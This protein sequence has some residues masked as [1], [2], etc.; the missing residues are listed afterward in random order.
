MD[1][2][3]DMPH[4]TFSNH[5]EKADVLGY[6]ATDK[7]KYLQMM[8]VEN[9]RLS[10]EVF[11]LHHFYTRN[12]TFSF[13]VASEHIRRTEDD[14]RQ[15]ELHYREKLSYLRGEMAAVAL[16]KQH[17][18]HQLDQL[19]QSL[20]TLKERE[21]SWMKSEKS[22]RAELSIANAAKQGS[23]EELHRLHADLEVVGSHMTVADISMKIGCQ[24]VSPLD[25]NDH[26]SMLKSSI[27]STVRD[28]QK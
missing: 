11:I 27:I 25:K 21:V 28:L 10:A 26:V 7:E 8:R 19:S 22:L 14:R 15:Q 23:E 24:T 5:L 20:S 17:V 13:G 4:D 6:S 18:H 1:A 9:E 2:S 16:E 12:R 3:S